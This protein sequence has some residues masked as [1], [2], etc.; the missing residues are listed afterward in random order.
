MF[1]EGGAEADRWVGIGP[2]DDEGAG[3]GVGISIFAEKLEGLLGGGLGICDD[4]VDGFLAVNVGGVLVHAG[5][6]VLDRLG[7]EADHGEDEGEDDEGGPVVLAVDAPLGVVTA[8]QEAEEVEAEPEGKEDD[9]EGEEDGGD[10]VAEDVVAHFVAEDVEDFVGCALG[11]GGVPDDD[12]LGGAEAGDVGVEGGD[13]VGGV[14]EEHAGRGDVDAAAAG[15]DALELGDEGWVGLGEGLEAVVEEFIDGG[16]DKDAEHGEDR[17]DDGHPEDE[18]PAAREL[19][20][21]PEEQHD[22]QAAEDEG[23]AKEF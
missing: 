23:E 14:H 4:A 12:A 20:D 2:E 16:G 19:A 9:D 1:G 3:V 10:D 8:E 17:H 21:D 15:Y 11:D 18:P 22:E 6:G 5:E 7:E 13:F